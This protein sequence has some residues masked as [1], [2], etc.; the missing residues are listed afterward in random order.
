TRSDG[1]NINLGELVGGAISTD[2]LS[3]LG[4]GIVADGALRWGLNNLGLE[5]NPAITVNIFVGTDLNGQTLDILRSLDGEGGWTN[6]G[7]GPPT[8]CV[9]A[10]GFCAF[11]A[12]KASV[13]A[14]THE[15]AEEN[16]GGGG[17]GG[18]GAAA[19]E[20]AGIEAEIPTTPETPG[21]TIEAAPAAAGEVEEGGT[22]P[23]V[24]PA[25]AEE[26]STA[27]A[28][29]PTPELPKPLPPFVAT[30]LSA[31]MLGTENTVVG[32]LVGAVLAALVAYL[33]YLLTK[34]LRKG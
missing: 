33:L 12:T 18:G 25:A 9:V 10:D 5:F 7:I 21:I 30:M 26:Q 32:M 11:T 34:K 22:P 1:E 24:A 3:G 31:L 17:G 23:A 28:L 16:G 13:Y 6:D 8:T 4:E 15:T 27:V 19:E 14:A 20:E 2:D 29:E